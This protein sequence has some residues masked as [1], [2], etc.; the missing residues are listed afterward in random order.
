MIYTSYKQFPS[1]QLLHG[2]REYRGEREHKNRYEKEEEREEENYKEME[3][4]ENKNVK[5]RREKKSKDYRGAT[6]IA[7]LKKRS[8]RRNKITKKK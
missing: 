3:D 2:K 7:S 1:V 6:L 5:K 4:E 8:K